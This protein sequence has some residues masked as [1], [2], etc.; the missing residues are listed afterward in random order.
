MKVHD[1]RLLS[2]ILNSRNSS[3]NLLLSQQTIPKSRENHDG[4]LESTLIIVSITPKAVRCILRILSST[5]LFY[6]CEE[7]LSYEQGLR[8]RLVVAGQVY[9]IYPRH[10]AAHGSDAS[11]Q[12]QS[13]MELGCRA[14]PHSLPTCKALADSA[15]PIR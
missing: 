3:S 6:C 11:H 9:R 15:K 1:L 13:G 8:Q 10:T 7:R 12:C 4:H 14:Q 2:A 5:S